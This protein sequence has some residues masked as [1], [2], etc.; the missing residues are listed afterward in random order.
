MQAELAFAQFY[1]LEIDRELRPGGDEGYDFEVNWGENNECS[2]D[3]KGTKYNDPKLMVREWKINKADRFV[4]ITA[5]DGVCT[6]Q[7]WI[8]AETL[9][10]RGEKVNRYNHTNYE[11][12]R[13]RLRP[14]PP[15]RCINRCEEIST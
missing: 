1:Q 7:G 15:S 11:L 10:Q 3:I 2:V 14:L 13:G 12:E 6:F 8:K 9:Q 5:D 4:L